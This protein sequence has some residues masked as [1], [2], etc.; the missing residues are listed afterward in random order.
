MKGLGRV[1][2]VCQMLK[3]HK[4]QAFQNQEQLRF[5]VRFVCCTCPKQTTN[6]F[7]LP[8][9]NSPQNRLEMRNRYYFYRYPKKYRHL[10]IMIPHLKNRRPP[11]DQ[12]LPTRPPP[13][14]GDAASSG[15]C[16]SAPSPRLWSAAPLSGATNNYQHNRAISYTCNV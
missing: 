10:P 11:T 4:L 12:A 7:R 5:S 2:G 15:P 8:A 1:K 9:N 6:C 16:S 13:A 14:C 3:A